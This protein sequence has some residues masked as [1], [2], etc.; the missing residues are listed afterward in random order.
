MSSTP[1]RTDE[2]A[3]L[4]ADRHA[5]D[6][7]DVYAHLSLGDGTAIIYDPEEPDTWLQSDYVVDLGV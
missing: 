4:P 1:S 6:G 7:L 2:T 5:P 3:D